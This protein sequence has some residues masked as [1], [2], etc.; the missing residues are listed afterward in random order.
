MVF[1]ALPFLN[2][3]RIEYPE[4]AFLHRGNRVMDQRVRHHFFTL[5][6]MM[7]VVSAVALFYGRLF[8]GYACP[9]MI[10][11]EWSVDVERAQRNGLTVGFRTSDC[12][13]A[14]AWLER[15]SMGF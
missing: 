14:I 11:S 15:S 9:Q 4:A 13:S 6:F 5:M 12:N 10:F 3:M 8:C 1:V 7:F 2:I